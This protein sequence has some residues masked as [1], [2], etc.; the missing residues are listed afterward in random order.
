MGRIV[1]E[2]MLKRREVYERYVEACRKAEIA[3]WPAAHFYSVKEMERAIASMRGEGEGEGEREGG[4]VIG[5]MIM[6]A[7]KVGADGVVV[8]WYPPSTGDT[9]GVPLSASERA[10]LRKLERSGQIEHERGAKWD[11]KEAREVLK[12]YAGMRAVHDGMIRR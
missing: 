3:A 6:V 10:L 5:G 2:G 1:T 4:E 11:V 12:E 7:E 9:G 8:D